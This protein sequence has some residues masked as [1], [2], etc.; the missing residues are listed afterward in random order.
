LQKQTRHNQDKK[1]GIYENRNDGY[2]R[3]DSAAMDTAEY[4]EADW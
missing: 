1:M 3:I 4:H 2:Q